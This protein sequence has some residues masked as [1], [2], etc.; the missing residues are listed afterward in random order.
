VWPDDARFL[1]DR[2]QLPGRELLARHAACLATTGTGAGAE[3][4]TTQAA[5]LQAHRNRVP[6]NRAVRRP[7]QAGTNMARW[8]RCHRNS[9]SRATTTTARSG[10]RSLASYAFER[11]VR[12]GRLRSG[13]ERPTGDRSSND[14][15]G[16][17]RICP[18]RG[19]RPW[20]R[21]GRERALSTTLTR[22][23]PAASGNFVANQTALMNNTA[24]GRGIGR[25]RSVSERRG[26][27][28]SHLANE[29]AGV[30]ERP[31]Y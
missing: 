1:P 3:A 24:R 30:T 21:P 16:R 25:Q 7:G 11:A 23:C 6:P 28:A 22:V 19:A 5:R 27:A 13:Q 14:S 18:S 15:G 31:T 4:S 20:V 2:P 17:L 29:S 10:A 9:R 8:C 26:A 12:F